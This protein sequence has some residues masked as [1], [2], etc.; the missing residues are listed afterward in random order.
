MHALIWFD[1]GPRSAPMRIMY[2]V[3]ALVTVWCLNCSS[4]E[5]LLSLWSGNEAGIMDC[6]SESRVSKQVESSADRS[7]TDAR[8]DSDQ[9]AALCGCNSCLAPEPAVARP[10]S[11]VPPAPSDL[12]T[13]EHAPA[14]IDRAPLVPPPQRVA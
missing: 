4:F 14:S 6:A 8:M 10:G 1:M 5:L 9:S 7:I 12:I 13:T 11:V 2:A 3:T